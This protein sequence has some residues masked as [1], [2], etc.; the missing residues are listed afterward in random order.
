MHSS[1]RAARA[2]PFLFVTLFV[3]LAAV[4]DD[5]SLDEILVTAELR[6]RKL[7]DLPASATVLDSRTLEIAGVQH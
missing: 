2:I 3:S 6:D 7:S 5:S 4:A 1:L